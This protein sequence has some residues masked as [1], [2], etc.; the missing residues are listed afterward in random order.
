MCSTAPSE[1][2]IGSPAARAAALASD[3]A[4]HGGKLSAPTATVAGGVASPGALVSGLEPALLVMEVITTTT[5]A[6]LT[7]TAPLIHSH[8]Y[9]APDRARATTRRVAHLDEFDVGSSGLFA[10]MG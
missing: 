6:A 5:I 7:I 3:G 8:L 9:R 10:P 1:L 4:G 2:N